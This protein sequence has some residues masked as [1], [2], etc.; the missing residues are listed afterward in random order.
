MWG[1]GFPRV[2]AKPFE[3]DCSGELA[4]SIL[5]FSY[6]YVA[7]LSY[8]QVQPRYQDRIRRLLS[9][10]VDAAPAVLLAPDGGPACYLGQAMAVPAP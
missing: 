2:W 1:L 5:F 3:H 8:P 4:Y 6:M 10:T 9:Y 7:Y